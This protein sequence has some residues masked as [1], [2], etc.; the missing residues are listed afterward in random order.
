MVPK[1]L[2]TQSRKT[3]TG[4]IR[5]LRKL[6]TTVEIRR[7]NKPAPCIL[8]TVFTNCRAFETRLLC[9]PYWT[10]ESWHLGNFIDLPQ[11]RQSQKI[12]FKSLPHFCGLHIAILLIFI[13][14]K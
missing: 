10:I 7:R 2:E 3:D 6:C 8:L 12:P 13:R 4:P 1:M 14:G 5:S 9:S 11:H